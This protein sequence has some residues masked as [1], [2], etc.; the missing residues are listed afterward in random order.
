MGTGLLTSAL[1]KPVPCWSTLPNA[2]RHQWANRTRFILLHA[3]KQ[4]MCASQ[5]RGSGGI[6]PRFPKHSQAVAVVVK[7][8]YLRG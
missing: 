6:S 5:L 1:T 2:K 8:G 7:A 4:A 3:S